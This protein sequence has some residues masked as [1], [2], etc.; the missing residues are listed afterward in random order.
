VEGN[1]FSDG[2]WAYRWDAENRLARMYMSS[3]PVNL[4]AP[5]LELRFGYDW[6][7]RRVSKVV[8]NRVNGVWQLQRRWKYVYDGWNMIAEVEEVTG[9]VRTHV[10]GLDLS[11]T[12][13]GAGGVGG[14]VAT[15]IHTGPDAGVYFPVYDGN[16]NVMGYVRASDGAMVAKYEYGPFGELIRA[17]GPLAQA[18]NLLFSTKYFDW[19]T[20]LSYYGYRYYNPH[21]GRWPSRDPIAERGGVNLYGFVGNNPVRRWDF[22]GKFGGPAWDQH[23]PQGGW[24]KDNLVLEF[25]K[26]EEIGNAWE[27][28]W[29]QPNDATYVNSLDQAIVEVK[30]TKAYKKYDSEGNCC[31]GHCIKHFVISAHGQ[32]GAINFIPG[33]EQYSALDNFD[34][35]KWNIPSEFSHDL[36]N[37]IHNHFKTELLFKL[38]NGVLC[39]GARVTLV[40]CFAGEGTEGTALMN[41]LKQHFPNAQTI[42]IYKGQV[43][44]RSNSIV[45]VEN[46]ETLLTITP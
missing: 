42:D 10:W 34:Q 43:G 5:N 24:C 21:T 40:V 32:P 8:S 26:K 14:L 45:K 23:R 28:F 29:L 35:F 22:L 33:S 20:G 13:H 1:L 39:Q 30:N 16:G 37:R 18:F 11:G 19:E 9:E 6:M 44:F 2:W 41:D 4:G 17:T 46:G 27:R 38:V 36:R 31:N 7:G 25:I 15:V 3:T 12:T